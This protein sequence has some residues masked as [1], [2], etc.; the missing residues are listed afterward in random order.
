MAEGAAFHCESSILSQLLYFS[1][2]SSIAAL[3]DIRE[4]VVARATRFA[5]GLVVMR[6]V[7]DW[8]PDIKNVG[9]FN[10][11]QDPS[12]IEK[13]RGLFRLI[14]KK[15]RV[16]ETNEV[17]TTEFY[18]VFRTKRDARESWWVDAFIFALLSLLSFL[19]AH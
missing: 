8:P 9:K 14:A 15:G 4:S 2:L 1:L 16:L 3:I 11:F 19:S 10:S 12:G 6:P 18:Q 17:V 7:T 13:R 5:F